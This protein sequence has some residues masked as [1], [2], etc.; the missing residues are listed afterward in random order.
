MSIL[1]TVKSKQAYTIVV[2]DCKNKIGDDQADNFIRI[3]KCGDLTPILGI[4]PIQLLAL[5]LAELRGNDVDQPRNLAKTV[6][7]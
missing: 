6:T 7:V 1:Q 4:I 5:H 2:T 3:P